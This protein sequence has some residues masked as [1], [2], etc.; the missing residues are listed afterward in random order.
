MARRDSRVAIT[1]RSGGGL[2]IRENREKEKVLQNTLQQGLQPR[3]PS[4]RPYAQLDQPAEPHA[5][6]LQGWI[7]ACVA[8]PT[9]I[10]QADV[11]G[12]PAVAKFGHP[13]DRQFFQLAL[14]NRG[15]IHCTAIRRDIEKPTALLR[16]DPT[17]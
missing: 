7:L 8:T 17:Q 15:D 13:G 16:R 14:F 11:E 1:I 10:V 9:A 4:N 2:F 3:L 6:Y 12:L 5:A